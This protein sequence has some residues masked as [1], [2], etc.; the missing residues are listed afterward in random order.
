MNWRRIAGLVCTLSL[1]L[2]LL[3]G[4][5]HH[6]DSL[7]GDQECAACAW[8][9]QSIDIP[10]TGSA[11]LPPDIIQSVVANPPEVLAFIP[12][13]NYLVRGPPFMAL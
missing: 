7:K 13:G 8:D 3:F 11:V 4:A 9:H 12:L 10:A 6:H 1:G 5:Q 2:G